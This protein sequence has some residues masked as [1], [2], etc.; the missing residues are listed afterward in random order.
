MRGT[1]FG[2]VI[3]LLE[4]NVCIVNCCALELA[5]SWFTFILYQIFVLLLSLVFSN[6][7]TLVLSNQS[8]IMIPHAM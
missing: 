5:E 2:V 4:L 8:C 1:Y 7:A 3:F 6:S